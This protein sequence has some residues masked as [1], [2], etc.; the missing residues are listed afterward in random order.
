MT[1]SQKRCM[2]QVLKLMLV[3]CI[4]EETTADNI[5]FNRVP[6]P[7]IKTNYQSEGQNG[8]KRVFDDDEYS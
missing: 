4:T 6:V 3:N 5:A 7:H 1:M 2:I 8:F